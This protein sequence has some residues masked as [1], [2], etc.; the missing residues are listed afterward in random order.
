MIHHHRSSMI[1][2]KSES[3]WCI[4]KPKQASPVATLAS[5]ASGSGN[6]DIVQADCDLSLCVMIWFYS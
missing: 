2:W 3:A 5:A 6:L 1:Q 4:L